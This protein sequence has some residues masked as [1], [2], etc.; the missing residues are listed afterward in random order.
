MR[1]LARYASYIDW[2]MTIGWLIVIVGTAY[3]GS[4]S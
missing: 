4:A 1:N 3:I 2:P